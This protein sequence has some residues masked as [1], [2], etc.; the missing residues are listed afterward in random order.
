M[1]PL[2]EVWETWNCFPFEMKPSRLVAASAICAHCGNSIKLFVWKDFVGFKVC[3]LL[4]TLLT[5]S[6]PLNLMTLTFPDSILISVAASFVV[7][8]YSLDKCCERKTVQ[9]STENVRH[10]HWKLFDK[11]T[12]KVFDNKNFDRKCSTATLGV[13]HFPSLTLLFYNIFRHSTSGFIKYSMGFSI[14]WKNWL[15]NLHGHGL[16]STFEHSD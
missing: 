7:S 8:K 3:L 11:W 10:I 16:F 1:R 9:F 2:F 4:T 12:K 13:E 15:L 5:N 6:L 14:Y